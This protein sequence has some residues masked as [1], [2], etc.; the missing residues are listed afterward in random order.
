MLQD[1]F[2]N[3]LNYKPSQQDYRIWL[4]INPAVWLV[5]MFAALL[6][7][8]LSVHLYAFSL[9]GNA[10]EPGKVAEPA[11]VAPVAEAAPV[12]AAPAAEAAPVEAAPAAEAAP[13][14]AAPAEEGAP[15]VVPVPVEVIV[16][17]E[18]A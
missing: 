8:A 9:P 4:V 14:E 11:A 16:V 1:A 12:E 7:I 2:R 3:V 18:A 10:W 15:A 13:V 17:P 6:V 5:P